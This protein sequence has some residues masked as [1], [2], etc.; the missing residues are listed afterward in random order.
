MKLL[1]QLAAF[2]LVASCFGMTTAGAAPIVFFGENQAPANKV[3]GD[4]VTARNSFLAGLTGVST[5]TFESLANGTTGP[6][7]LGFNGSSGTIKA[8]LSGEGNVETSTGAG[9]FNTTTGGSKFF[10]VSGDFTV[11]FDK[12][13]SAF[14]FY[15]TDIGDFNGNITLALAG[16]GSTTLVVPNTLNGADGSLLFFG[17]ID[18]TA[19]YTSVTFGNT[20]S[21][22]DYFG[23]D[24]LVIG[25]H[26]QVTVDVPE[27]GSLALLAIALAGMTVFLRRKPKA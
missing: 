6:L 10:E 24:D 20:A 4:P 2:V 15:G 8:T 22:T 23:F 9:R 26:N 21:G 3:S 25:D 13:I 7:S 14:G 16:G 1:K 19:S 17:F 12:A 27:P 18:P 5:Q 11:T